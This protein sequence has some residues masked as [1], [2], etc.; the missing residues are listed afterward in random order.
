MGRQGEGEINSNGELFVEM[1]AFNSMVIGG[2]IFPQKS[3]PK[4]IWVSPDHN[5]ENH[6][7]HMCVGRA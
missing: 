4:A 3:I 6:I 5:T 1:C 7:D 2:S